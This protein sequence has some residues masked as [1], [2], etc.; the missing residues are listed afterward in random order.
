MK[1]HSTIK[2]L[3]RIEGLVSILSAEYGDPL[4]YNQAD[5]LDEIV[6][7]LL[8]EKTDEEKYVSTFKKLKA[9]FPCWEDLL[10]A[11]VSDIRKIIKDAGMGNRRAVLIKGALQRI[12]KT[13]GRLN[14]SL[15]RS[16]LAE[17]AQEILCGLPGIGPKAARCVLLYC[18]DK[19]VL[20][21]DIHT[22][23]LA[24]RLG[25]L[26]RTVSYDQSHDILAKII[27]PVLRRKFHVNAV[28]HG[29]QRCFAENPKC[30][31]CP[32]NEFC[33]HPKA[34]KPVKIEVRPRPLAIDLF[35]GAGG[36][37]L[38]FRKAGFQIVQAVEC[39]SH[40]AET[41]RKN[42]PETD[43]IESPIEKLDPVECMARLGIRSGD[44][45]VLIGGPPCQG[46]SES[47]RRTRTIDNP[48][49]HLYREFVRFL[50]VLRPAW[51][52]ME[53]VAGLR[54]LAKASILKRIVLECRKL[55]YAVEWKVLNAADYG[56]PQMRRRLFIV[57]N[58]L[59]LPVAF[60]EPTHGRGKRPWVT[61][62]QA[63][64]DLPRLENGA[65]EDCLT[66]PS[67]RRRFFR[68]P[69]SHYQMR[70]RAGMN[71]SMKVQGNLVTDSA[72][73]ILERYRHIKAGQN[74]EAIPDDL[75][76]NYEDS[77]RCHTGIYHRL[78]WNKPAKVIGNFRKNMLIHPRDH[79][80]LSVREAARLQ[81][82]PDN[83]I[84]VGSIGFQQQQVADAVP[85]LLAEA[86]ARSINSASAKRRLTPPVAVGKAA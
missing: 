77:A 81:S 20:P 59:G 83:Y 16:M 12:K 84:F 4:L 38:G 66:Y 55:G 60:A 79:R 40:A 64:G 27:P 35:A 41:Y 76:D 70:M 58:R 65:D 44:L 19:P 24:I 33:L 45:T 6:F 21:V 85:P 37:S 49:N 8:S 34:K 80:G 63:I 11:H 9:R 42:H 62:R 68:K 71:G 29:R 47:N 30:D 1:S 53:N 14:L 69:I 67:L 56:V 36:V 7:I 73:K 13:C 43:V 48:R 23:R 46:F 51:F 17:D 28:A 52:V 3:P 57:G 2:S 31:G 74:W 10:T 5:P 61:V 39:N 25:L 50:R 86:V 32:L 82:F 26:S 22:Y 18:F 54:T 78:D 15:L 75:M 72:Q